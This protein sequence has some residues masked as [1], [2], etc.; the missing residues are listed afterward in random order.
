MLVNYYGKQIVKLLESKG[1]YIVKMKIFFI[2]YKELKKYLRLYLQI[3]I[4]VKL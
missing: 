4:Q 3:W 1:Y 2:H